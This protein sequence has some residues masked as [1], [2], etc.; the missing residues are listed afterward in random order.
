MLWTAESRDAANN[1]NMSNFNSPILQEDRSHHYGGYQKPLD[2][3]Q[4]EGK[5]HR[6][7]VTVI[8]TL[9]LSVGPAGIGR[10]HHHRALHVDDE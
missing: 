5:Q 6:S 8:P 4:N 3:E 2:Q 10:E 1:L 9:G 7:L